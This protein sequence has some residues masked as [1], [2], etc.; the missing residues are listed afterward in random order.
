MSEEKKHQG[1]QKFRYFLQKSEQQD[2][3]Y[4]GE[5]LSA[6]AAF[7]IHVCFKTDVFIKKKPKCFANIFGKLLPHFCK[8][9]SEVF[10]I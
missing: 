7:K 8:V 3:L 1:A 9:Q 4:Q 2:C 5:T 6:P 10:P